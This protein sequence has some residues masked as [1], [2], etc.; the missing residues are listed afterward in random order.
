[1]YKLHTFVKDR[2]PNA[3]CLETVAVSKAVVEQLE[4]VTDGVVAEASWFEVTAMHLVFPFG[5]DSAVFETYNIVCKYG[6][7]T[8]SS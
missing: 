1:M 2:H 4:A 3:V 6:G 5:M 8:V 7:P